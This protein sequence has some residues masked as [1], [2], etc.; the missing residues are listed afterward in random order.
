MICLCR[1]TASGIYDRMSCYELSTA[2]RSVVVFL[3]THR[4]SGGDEFQS[5]LVRAIMNSSVFVPI[6]SVEGMTRMLTYDCDTVDNVLFEWICAL[7]C[8]G[9]DK[10]KLRSIY[11]ILFGS[12]RGSIVGSISEERFVERLPTVVPSKTVELVVQYLEEL[13]IGIS[14]ELRMLSVQDIMKRLFKF[15][16][17]DVSINQTN[18]CGDAVFD[19]VRR[20]FVETSV[21]LSSPSKTEAKESGQDLPQAPENIV[22]SAPQS[23]TTSKRPLKTLTVPEVAN[24][25]TSPEVELSSYSDLFVP[26]FYLSCPNQLVLVLNCVKELFIVSSGPGVHDSEEEFDDNFEEYIQP[27]KSSDDMIPVVEDLSLGSAYK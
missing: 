4:L 23:Q 1:T 10:S 17:L 24:L 14:D 18:I 19:V 8:I 6:V 16:Y 11:P 13:G 5:H 12:R 27:V 25:L 21:T 7:S 2:F 15:M 20:H 3:D 26:T 22:V 9:H